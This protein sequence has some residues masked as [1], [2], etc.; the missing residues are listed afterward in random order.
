M[1]TKGSSYVTEY[2][3]EG[4]RLV[5]ENIIMLLYRILRY[6]DETASGSDPRTSAPSLDDLRPVDESGSYLLHASVRVEDGSK[7]DI[8][9]RGQNELLR[10]RE[11]MKGSVDLR[12]VDRLCLDTRYR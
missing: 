11:M 8:V 2:I 10:F 3:Q 9:A 12:V 7:P 6:P 5:Y 1:P 4:H